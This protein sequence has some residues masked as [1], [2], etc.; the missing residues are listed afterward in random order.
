[1]PFGLGPRMCP[2]YP[3][4]F[5]EMKALLAVVARRSSWRLE[6]SASE[7]QWAKFPMPRPLQGLWAVFEEGGLQGRAR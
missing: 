4:A 6:G 5:L 3:L 1:V 2:G 7:V